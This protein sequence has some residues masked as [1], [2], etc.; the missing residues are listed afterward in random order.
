MV[1]YLFLTFLWIHKLSLLCLG[2]SAFHLQ[3]NRPK[4]PQ[5]CNPHCFIDIFAPQDFL[6]E[7]L[8]Q[9]NIRC[10]HSTIRE[11]DTLLLP[12]FA[13]EVPGGVWDSVKKAAV[14]IGSGILFLAAFG[15]SLTWQDFLT[16]L[17]CYNKPIVC[18]KMNL[19]S[20]LH[21]CTI[22]IKKGQDREPNRREPDGRHQDSAKQDWTGR[23]IRSKLYLF[24]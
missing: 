21:Q 12:F 23:L 5:G 17:Q 8:M 7:T 10:L 2:R 18:F 20:S 13:Q 9:L 11:V 19:R 15:N 6:W 1:Y 24:S 3:L 14:V 16:S 4:K 22:I